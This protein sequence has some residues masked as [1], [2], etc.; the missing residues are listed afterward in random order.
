MNSSQDYIEKSKIALGRVIAPLA[1]W[2]YRAIDFEKG[3]PDELLIEAIL[4]NGND[5]LRKRLFKLYKSG[6]IKN[7]WKEKVIIQGPRLDFLNQ[8]IAK[9]FFNIVDP[10]KYIR[11]AYS[12]N[13]LYARFSS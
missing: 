6:E 5:P 4:V 2:S 11:R 7:V 9:D 12:K 8:K 3:I 10:E 1:F 13:N